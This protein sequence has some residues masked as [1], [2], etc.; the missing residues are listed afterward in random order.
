MIHIR[1][2]HE[3][4]NSKRRFACGIGPELPAGDTYYFP[5]DALAYH[6]SDCPGCNPHGPEQLGTP[7]SEL[8]GR[9]GRA[10]FAKFQAI[11]ASW[12]YG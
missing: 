7:L 12:G 5:G 1:I 9:P 3:P 2:D 6:K 11:A 4:E 8:S 10:G